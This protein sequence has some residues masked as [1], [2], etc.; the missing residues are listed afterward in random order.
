M[1]PLRCRSHREQ[2][3]T[4]RNRFVDRFP[5]HARIGRIAKHQ[6]RLRL[7][8]HV[9]KVGLLED[10]RKGIDGQPQYPAADQHRHDLLAVP[11]GKA[12]KVTA[13]VTKATQVQCDPNDAPPHLAAR[14]LPA[15]VGIDLYDAVGRAG[16]HIEHDAANTGG[17]IEYGRVPLAENGAGSVQPRL[18]SS[19]TRAVVVST[20]TWWGELFACLAAASELAALAKQVKCLLT[21]IKSCVMAKFPIAHANSSGVR[22][23]RLLAVELMCSFDALASRMMID[24]MSERTTASHS[25]W[26]IGG[27]GLKW[28]RNS[29][30]SYLLRIHAS[31]SS[32]EL[33]GVGFTR[34]RVFAS[35]T[36]FARLLPIASI[37]LRWPGLE[38]TRLRIDCIDAMSL[39]FSGFD[40]DDSMP[41]KLLK[42]SCSIT[43]THSSRSSE[44]DASKCH[45]LLSSE[46]M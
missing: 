26:P 35:Q 36:E 16:E 25:C 6:P 1:N 33:A 15:R 14:R 42:I 29:L 45:C 3:R 44:L 30:P 13:P 11:A 17:R 46:T 10:G 31:F 34:P 24:F 38:G 8:H 40:L 43:D 19:S 28:G 41:C 39:G 37:T 4:V 9:H 20:F 18:V 5:H 2:L 32:R 23:S 22:R 27:D 21:Q 7:L 12:D